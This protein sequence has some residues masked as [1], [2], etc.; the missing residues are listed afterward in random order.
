MSKT[1]NDTRLDSYSENAASSATVA[2]PEKAAPGRLDAWETRFRQFIAAL[3]VADAAHDLAHVQRVVVNARH[4]AEAENADLAVVIPAAWLHDCVSVCKG[5]AQRSQA[6][7]LSAAKALQLLSEWG[8]PEKYLS[9][10]AHAIEAHSWSA[11]ITPQTLEAKIVQDADR[12]DSVG[13]IGV[14]RAILVGGTLGRE[15]YHP[16]DPLCEHR[17]PDDKRYTLDHFFTKLLHLKD[18]FHTAA[19]RAEAE[20]RHQRMHDYLQALKAE[21]M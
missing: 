19:A 8:Y 18:G 6:S 5:S 2:T 3:P 12:I 17:Q 20:K 10:I 13:A 16:D 21:V 9:A 14:A 11:G 7:R 15:L 4:F 1:T